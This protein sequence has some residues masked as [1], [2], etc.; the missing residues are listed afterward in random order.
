[1][2]SFLICNGLVFRFCFLHCMNRVSLRIQFECKKIRIRENSV[3]GHFSCS[4]GISN[5]KKYLIKDDIHIVKNIFQMK[6]AT[7]C[8]EIVT[9]V[10]CVNILSYQLSVIVVF[11]NML[12][13][14]IT[15]KKKTEVYFIIRLLSRR[16][17][18]VKI[19]YNNSNKNQA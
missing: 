4:A 3:F 18:E 17:C 14:L 8:S 6:Q 11:V 15:K 16:L 19:K 13:K 10:L 1:M 2:F 7:L 12:M 5:L 9:N